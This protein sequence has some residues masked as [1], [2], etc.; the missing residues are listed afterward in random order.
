MMFYID[1]IIIKTYPKDMTIIPAIITIIK[2]PHY[3]YNYD[4]HFLGYFFFF[5]SSNSHFL[6]TSCLT[7]ANFKNS[8]TFPVHILYVPNPPPAHYITNT[9][10][11]NIPITILSCLCKSKSV[12][13]IIP[14]PWTMPFQKWICFYSALN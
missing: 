4:S 13:R 12:N 1:D 5:L 8:L 10:T 14:I 7:K 3:Y 9:I 11:S 6:P 2:W